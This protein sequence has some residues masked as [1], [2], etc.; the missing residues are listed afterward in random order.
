MC[1]IDDEKRRERESNVNN[2]HKHAENGRQIDEESLLQINKLID[3]GTV[4]SKK[5]RK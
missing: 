2:R 5:K 3:T 4:I 1:K